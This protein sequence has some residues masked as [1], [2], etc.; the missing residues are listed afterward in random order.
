[1]SIIWAHSAV[2]YASRATSDHVSTSTPSREV[3]GG[4]S[5]RSHVGS[6]AAGGTIDDAHVALKRRAERRG[7]VPQH[8][9]AR[10]IEN[11]AIG[12]KDEDPC[13]EELL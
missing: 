1:M 12:G 6:C 8:R 4:S 5:A 11:L 9:A 10:E 7:H 13:A 2:G 3:V